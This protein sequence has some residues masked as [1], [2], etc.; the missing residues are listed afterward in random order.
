MKAIKRLLCPVDFSERSAEALRYAAAL[1]LTLNGELAI[2]HVSARGPQPTD[3]KGSSDVSLGAFASQV[4]GLEPSIQLLE[5]QGDAVEEILGAAAAIASD[6]VVM[7]SRGRTGLQRLLLGSVTERIIRR[8]P[9]PVLTVPLGWR[10]GGGEA[11]KLASVLCAVDFSEP[12]GRAVDYAATI[13]EAGRAQLV[14]VHVLEWAEELEKA[15]NTGN[16]LL[17]SSED[18]AIEGM[19]MLLTNDVLVRCAPELV[20]GRGAPADEVLRIVQE[21]QVDLVVL[22]IRR[23]NP[24]DLA[25]FGSTAQQLIRDGRCAVLAVHGGQ[26]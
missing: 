1:R 19:R 13:A 20:V 9:A 21:R 16:S 4:V 8:S 12:S 18:D 26:Q 5:R 2:L 17:P 15:P 23:R 11:I 22:G 25:V 3:A 6:V 7:G 10:K 14:L 24:I